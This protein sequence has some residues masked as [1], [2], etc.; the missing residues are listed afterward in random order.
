MS[1]AIPSQ[2]Y[3]WSLPLLMSTNGNTARDGRRAGLG[4]T[5]RVTVTPGVKSCSLRRVS[6]SSFMLEQRLSFDLA[7]ACETTFCRSEETACRKA[8][9][10]MGSLCKME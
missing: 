6:D 5:V 1:S 7:R 3:S 2:R 10:D 8:L 9:N 4:E